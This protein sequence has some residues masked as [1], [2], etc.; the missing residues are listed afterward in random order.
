MEAWRWPAPGTV[1]SWSSNCRDLTRL[2]GGGRLVTDP[3][4]GPWDTITLLLSVPFQG[5]LGLPGAPGIDGE[6]VSEPFIFLV[7]L[8]P[9]VMSGGR[10]GHVCTCVCVN[11][12]VGR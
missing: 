3:S 4:W 10:G 12:E 9:G 11:A 5:E 8:V 1:A 2:V 7:I 6:K